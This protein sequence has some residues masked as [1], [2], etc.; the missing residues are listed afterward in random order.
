MGHI[1][2]QPGRS[3]TVGML[4]SA[5]WAQEMSVMWQVGS[6]MMSGRGKVPREM[7]TANTWSHTSCESVSDRGSSIS[8]SRCAAASCSQARCWWWSL[9]TRRRGAGRAVAASSSPVTKICYVVLESAHA[10]GTTS[11][12]LQKELGYARQV[13]QR[14]HLHCTL[15]G[16]GQEEHLALGVLAG[17]RWLEEGWAAGGILFWRCIDLGGR[18]SGGSTQIPEFE[19]VA[20][21]LI[22]TLN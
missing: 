2:A 8:A 7:L 17:H 18:R 19:V 6:N 16:K 10:G 14:Q 13:L 3:W 9:L 4:T 11:W 21:G 22:I 5:L 12:T 15:P 20:M 1:C